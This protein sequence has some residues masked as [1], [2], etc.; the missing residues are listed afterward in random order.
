MAASNSDQNTEKPK[1]RTPK[2]TAKS[3]STRE[4]IIA[5]AI[6]LF[7]TKG[8]GRTSLSEIS[9]RAGIDPSSFYYYFP[10][11]EALID[12]VFDQGNTVPPLTLLE[13]LSNNRAAQLCSLIMFDTVRKCELPVDFNELETIATQNREAFG[14]FF[15]HYRMLYK[16]IVTILQRGIAEN[17]FTPCTPD[18]RAVSILSLDE[19]LQH[20]FHAKHRNELILEASGYPVRNYTPENIAQMAAY[21]I[22]PSIVADPAIME[23]AIKE[24]TKLYYQLEEEMEHKR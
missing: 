23:T 3:R 6:E 2:S 12:T 1:A 19:G 15:E 13:E 14:G 4:S 17:V 20:H 21:S 16:S 7:R 11:K 18:V 24:G 22:M 9:R 10:S 5:V 8:Y